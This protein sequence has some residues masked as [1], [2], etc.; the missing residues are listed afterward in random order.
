[1]L[2]QAVPYGGE[3]GISKDP[4]SFATNGSRIYFSDKSRNAILRLSNDGL[5]VISNKGMKSYFRSLLNAQVLPIVG[6]FD[7]YS[8]QYIISFD[9]ADVDKIESISFKE[10]VDG[11]VSRL[12]FVIKAGLSING[13]LYSFNSGNLYQHHHPGVVR[14]LF[15]GTQYSSG[16]QIIMNDEPS[17]VKNFKTI[18]YEGSQAKS[19]SK[20]GW[21][22]DTIETDLQSGKIIEF[23]DK[24]G[25]WFANTSGVDTT[26]NNLDSKE[27]SIQGLGQLNSYTAI[28]LPPIVTVQPT[29]SNVGQAT[30]TAAATFKNESGLAVTY[31]VYFGTNAV[32]TS[33]TLYLVETNTNTTFTPTYSPVGLTSNTTYYVTFVADTNEFSD[34]LTNTAN[35]TTTANCSFNL[36]IS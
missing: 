30:F 25:K 10:D 20:E 23:K 5:T 21:H 28:N 3:Y 17:A 1:V 14:N 24:E 7:A 12:G 27:F 33:N 6:T 4:E 19:S 16:I 2:G 29:F 26:L 32:A 15:Y 11:W 9:N 34:V 35:I 36:G 13:E 18:Y 8:D 31:R 22:V